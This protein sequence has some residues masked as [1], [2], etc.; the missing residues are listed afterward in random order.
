[1]AEPTQD[2]IARLAAAFEAFTRNFKVAEAEAAADNALNAL[3]QSTLVFV[4][5][6]PGCALTDV[7]RFLNVAMTTMSSATD[8]LVKKGLI[9]RERPEEN[10][11]SVALVATAAGQGIVDR[12]FQV[13]R[14]LCRL[15]LSRLDERERAELIRIAGKIANTE[16]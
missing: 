4:A 14:D 1:M 5:E 8:R 15:M 16:S 2:D 12:H 10:R 13:F 3:D 7:A 6:N 11:R 9:E